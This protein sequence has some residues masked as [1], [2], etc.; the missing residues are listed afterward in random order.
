[1]QS[2]ELIQINAKLSQIQNQIRYSI[3]QVWA[4]LDLLTNMAQAGVDD[5]KLKTVAA[6]VK[7]ETAKLKAAVVK[8]LN[9]DH[10]TRVDGSTETIS[11]VGDV[12]M[13]QSV[14]ALVAAIAAEDT[15]IDSAVT[16]ING[17]A[18]QLKAAIAAALAGGATAA[19]LAP[20][21]T[22]LTDVQSKTTA[23]SAAVVANTPAGP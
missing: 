6:N 11:P 19:E 18:G 12:E 21:S 1:M 16:L 13:A 4:I 7:A 23:L 3:E 8:S 14:D 9:R 17:F 20:L 2:D 5:A 10:V 15:V 22:L